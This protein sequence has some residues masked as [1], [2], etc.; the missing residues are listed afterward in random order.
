MCESLSLSNAHISCVKARTVVRPVVWSGLMWAGP[1][2]VEPRAAIKRRQQ[3]CARTTGAQRRVLTAPLHQPHE[4]PAQL[5]L[6]RSARN[7]NMLPFRPAHW[8]IHNTQ[9]HNSQPPSRT[10]T[11]AT[12]GELPKITFVGESSRCFPLLNENENEINCR[13]SER[14]KFYSS[15][16]NFSS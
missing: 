6:R 3:L 16:S 14:L 13:N 15:N 2:G 10:W 4:E 5:S 9:G 11:T 8:L 12:G 7:R 1:A